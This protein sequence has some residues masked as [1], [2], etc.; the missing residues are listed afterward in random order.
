MFFQNRLVSIS[1]FFKIDFRHFRTNSTEIARIAPRRH[2]FAFSQKMPPAPPLRARR[3]QNRGG[4]LNNSGRA[5]TASSVSPSPFLPLLSATE[6]SSAGVYIP[7]HSALPGGYPGGYPEGGP[8]APTSFF[9]APW[10]PFASMPCSAL[11]ITAPT[12]V[13]PDDPATSSPG[14][15]CGARLQCNFLTLH[16]WS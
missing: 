4:A 1:T 11:S 6:R 12:D 13:V 15:L 8:L 10:E 9:G 16:Q 2:F 7:V 14:F 5:R 3:L